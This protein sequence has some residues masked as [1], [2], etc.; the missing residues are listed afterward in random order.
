MSLYS[1]AP[2]PIREAIEVAHQQ[3][4][5]EFTSD[6]TWWTGAERAAIV[7]EARRARAEAGFAKMDPVVDASGET[8]EIPD[9][10]RAVA[11]VVAAK[12]MTMTRELFDSALAD[13]LKE[14]QY[15]E[16]VSVA[17]RTV[18]LDI[19]ATALGVTPRAL[20]STHSGAPSRVRPS[21]AADEGAWANTVPSSGRGG[22]EA[23]ALYGKAPAANILRA[24]SLVPAEATAAMRLGAAQYVGSDNFSN[25]AFTYDPGITRPEVEY[26]AS[27]VSVLNDCFY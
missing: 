21:T 11:R 6:G 22:E 26:L 8:A 18:N 17:A 7:V 19:F 15:V 4:L 25:L 23:L 16:T 3:E 1:D 10:A 24:V 9:A 27:R 20:P 13:G 2:H 5:A 14:E 12:P